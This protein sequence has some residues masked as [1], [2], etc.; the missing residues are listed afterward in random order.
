MHIST[1]LY[2]TILYF[3]VQVTSLV[4]LGV[5]LARKEELA[6]T[7]VQSLRI[8]LAIK[9]GSILHVSKQVRAIAVLF[10]TAVLTT[11]L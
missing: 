11:V 4:R 2:R 9:P 10:C 6:S 8:L 3:S 5:R 7:V 1:V